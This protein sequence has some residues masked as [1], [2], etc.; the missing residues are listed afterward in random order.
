MLRHSFVVGSALG[1]VLALSAQAATLITLDRTPSVYGVELRH[2]ARVVADS[3]CA[4]ASR[5]SSRSDFD[6]VAWDGG[7][8]S[9][10]VPFRQPYVDGG[11][12]PPCSSAFEDEC[13]KEAEDFAHHLVAVRRPQLEDV[14][15]AMADAVALP[16]PRAHE[17]C[18]APV[19]ANALEADAAVIISDF[20]PDGAC[21]AA[22]I[23]QAP[24]GSRVL[25]IVVASPADAD[26][27]IGERV[28]E[29]RA[30]GYVAVSSYALGS[31]DWSKF[32]GERKP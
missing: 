7:G 17:S 31:V 26:D 22:G 24:R 10:R 1:A 30:L 5:S 25:C 15:R 27:A 28:A 14:R 32:V 6:F 11:A 3:L 23:P 9:L 20:R 13:E 4:A 2:V 19:F 12:P 29:L 8:L 18:F 21:N 16:V